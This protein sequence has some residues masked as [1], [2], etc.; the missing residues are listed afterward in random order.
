MNPSLLPPVR[1]LAVVTLIALAGC[2]TARPGPEV[3]EADGTLADAQRA[4][5]GGA[6]EQTWAEMM[7][8]AQALEVG[9]IRAAYVDRPTVAINGTIIEDLAEQWKSTARWL[10]SLRQLEAS[11][12][13]VHLE[14][15]SPTAAVATMNHHLRWT[16]TS[17]VMGEWNSAW[18]AVFRQVEGH[19]K[20]VYSHE[21][22]APATPT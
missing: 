5:I 18:T 15:L 22:I 1:P 16:D 17:G 14:V 12:D 10:G 11:Y 3:A 2:H 19:W 9:R 6:V 8:G 21:S 20:I 4:A 13:H 7:R